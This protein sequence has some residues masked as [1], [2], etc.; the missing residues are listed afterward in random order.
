MNHNHVKDTSSLSINASL[1]ALLTEKV[2]VVNQPLVVLYP[3]TF[4]LKAVFVP[5]AYHELPLVGALSPEVC[6]VTLK[7]EKKC[8][9]IC[10]NT[11]TR[12]PTFQTMFYLSP[13]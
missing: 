11:H 6:Y 8:M 3:S 1:P 10:I 9:Y 12:P 4:H 7:K 5:L 13:K 2:W